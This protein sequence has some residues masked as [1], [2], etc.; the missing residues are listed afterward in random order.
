MLR[1]VSRM[2]ERMGR[3][4]VFARLKPGM[5]VSMVV[6]PPNLAPTKQ[7]FVTRK[8]VSQA[9]WSLMP[10]DDAQLRKLVGRRPTRRKFVTK[11]Y[12]D[13]EGLHIHE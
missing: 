4:Q 10:L 13:M 3:A 1:A 11:G 2:D 12:E 7:F 5:L 6:T 9:S 8:R